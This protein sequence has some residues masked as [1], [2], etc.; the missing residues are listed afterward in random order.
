MKINIT[1]NNAAALTS[2]DKYK[3]GLQGCL[4]DP[5]RKKLVVTNGHALIMYPIHLEEGEECA[6]AVV[7]SDIFADTE[8]AKKSAEYCF[9]GRAVYQDAA[10][11]KEREYIDES[12]PK[13]ENVLKQDQPVAYTI[14]LD[15]NLLAKVARAI[16]GG[17]NDQKTVTLDIT[18]PRSALFFETSELYKGEKISGLIMPINDDKNGRPILQHPIKDHFGHSKKAEVNKK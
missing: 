1:K 9:N 10:G 4:I 13:Y 17:A 8:K 5:D 15:L 12:Y 7:P 3:P 14:T 16:P 2:K 18:G 11:T 6:K